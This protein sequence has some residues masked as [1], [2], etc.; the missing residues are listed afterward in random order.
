[1]ESFAVVEEV[2]M[3]IADVDTHDGVADGTLGEATKDRVESIIVDG[4][5]HVGIGV[6][7]FGIEEATLGLA[8][9]L[10]GMVVVVAEM[11]VADVDKSVA[12][13]IA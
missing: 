8:G 12:H 5:L 4:E 6:D 9:I 13:F 10:A 2:G 7:M 3:Q 1:M 11:Q